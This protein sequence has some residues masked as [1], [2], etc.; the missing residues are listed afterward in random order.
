MAN[1]LDNPLLAGS[2]GLSLDNLDF[3]ALRDFSTGIDTQET[4]AG[5]LHSN[6]RGYIGDDGNIY[7]KELT[8]NKQT[9]EMEREYTDEQLYFWTPPQE[10]G[11]R[12]MSA[13]QEEAGAGRDT[14]GAQGLYT[15]AEIQEAFEAD[16]G[17]GYLKQ[18]TTWDKY[19]NFIEQSTA[20]FAD[21]EYNDLTDGNMTAWDFQD[22][23]EYM[24][25]LEETGIPL[26]YTNDDGDVFNWNGTGYSKDYKVDDSIQIGTINK[27]LL[28]GALGFL[29]GPLIISALTPTLGIAGAK[30]ATS[31]ITG[32]AK[33]YMTDGE[34]SWED[35]LMSAA[36]SYGGSEL[37]GA[38]EGSGVLGDIGSKITEFG[39][40]IANGG[41]DILTAALQAG[42][43]SLV[44][45]LVNEGEIDWKDAA[46]AALISGGTTALTSYLSGIGK[47]DEIDNLEEWDEYDEWQQ[48]AINSDI[49]DPFLNP[50]YKTVGDGLVMNINTGEVFSQGGTGGKSHGTFKDLDRDG[51]GTLSGDDL[52]Q[53]NTPNRDLKN[54]YGY[55]MGDTVYVDANGN[56]VDPGLVKLGRDGQYYG[57]DANGNRVVVDSAT[58][59]QAFGGDKG[60]LK[61][62]FGLNE[63]GSVS[64]TEGAIYHENGELAYERT[65]GQW[66][67]ANGNIVDDPT[68]ADELTM[69]AAKAIDEPIDQIDYTDANGNPVRFGKT[70]LRDGYEN[71]QYAGTIY[72]RNGQRYEFD[73][74]TGLYKYVGDV[75]NPGATAD[76]WYD[77]VT[78]TTYQHDSENKLVIT[79]YDE[80]I[81]QT[82]PETPETK[83]ETDSKDGGNQDGNT[84][85][86]SSGSPDAPGSGGN[87]GGTPDNNPTPTP[88][89]NNTGI[90]DTTISTI[91]QIAGKTVSE[92]I[93][94]LNNGASV[95]E[96]IA[97]A[98]DTPASD[99][100][101]APPSDDTPTTD[102]PPVDDGGGTTD[103]TTDGTGGT[104][105]TP[106]PGT[107][108]DGNGDAGTDGNGG[109][110]ATG[111]DDGTT[112]SDGSGGTG[113][114]GDDQGTNDDGTGTDTDGGGF[115]AGDEG[116]GD[117][118][119]DGSG[120]GSGDGNGSGNGLG[121]GNGGGNGMLGGGNGGSETSWSPLPPPITL[122]PAYFKT[123]AA[124]KNRRAPIMR[125]LF[126]DLMG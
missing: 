22:S 60:G 43:M 110:D 92:V 37:S 12:G 32:L 24:A 104:D 62:Q 114:N 27:L 52:T 41:G 20:L 38:L 7:R 94:A 86:D 9:G 109:D 69:I 119:G 118:Y 89:V 102:Q 15:K 10:L 42:G 50:N 82:D 25:L 8:Y 126:E 34:L 115:G 111:D 108:G 73:P 117:G 4:E 71:G 1:A 83:T 63:D 79:K 30:A 124:Q 84:G 51:D 120:D 99:N 53:I 93:N 11:D 101:G 26:Q 59:D 23:P 55:E 56:P 66:R 45:Q 64:T 78:G 113:D 31:A 65:N 87:D 28:G 40:D 68:Q 91:A 70:P 100:G 77:P 122:K 2:E 44:T 14:F 123:A 61:W 97:T 85:A 81:D 35:A 19:W 29:A 16:Q 54:I 80:P 48:E 72:G 74:K 90:P 76:Q 105:D 112:D 95:S 98:G 88:P 107:D 39:D 125:R 21:P 106:I 33:S 17:M 13:D 103:G 46:T 49:K 57:Y 58:Y 121:M 3:D 67:D 96:I 116:Y 18:F 6:H 36:L 47:S 75:D 5:A